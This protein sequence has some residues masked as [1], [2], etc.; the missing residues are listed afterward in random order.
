M[1]MKPFKLLRKTGLSLLILAL[2]INLLSCSGKPTKEQY[3]D[4]FS[5]FVDEVTREAKEYT[6]ED[7]QKADK[8]FRKFVEQNSPEYD[9]LLTSDERKLIGKLEGKYLM[10]RAKS[11]FKKMKKE[12]KELKD[13]GEGFFEAVKEN[14][15]DNGIDVDKMTE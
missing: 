15:K 10:L 9:G 8:Q 11:G 12:L 4:S 14:L 3:I 7:W 13:Q 5:E 2:F 6:E 1:R